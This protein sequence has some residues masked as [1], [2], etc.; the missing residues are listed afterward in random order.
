M[1]ICIFG[2]GAIGGYIGTKLAVSGA[3][4]S[5]VARGPN[6]AA[7]REKGVKL[8]SEGQT[9]VAR[10]PATD[11]PNELGLQ[12]YV[13]LAVKAHALVGAADSIQPLLGP[14]TTLIPA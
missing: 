8:L 9:F 1:K 10:P 3:D 6:L 12:D 5:F 13:V 4:V 14:K 2:A 7:I 11:N